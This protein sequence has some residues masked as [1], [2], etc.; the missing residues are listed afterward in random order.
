MQHEGCSWRSSRSLRYAT[1][2]ILLIYG[3][4]I[5]VA[6]TYGVIFSVIKNPVIVSEKRA[7]QDVG[8][9]GTTDMDE[10]TDKRE[11]TNKGSA[12]RS[13]HS[14]QALDWKVTAASI[15]QN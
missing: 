11:S 15:P 6:Y 12:A 7:G 13:K 10:T 4:K 2:F 9:A 14:A 8:G 5:A 1:F 3:L